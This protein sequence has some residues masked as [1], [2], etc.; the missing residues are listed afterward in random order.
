MGLAQLFIEEQVEVVATAVQLLA[1]KGRGISSWLQP[2]LGHNSPLLVAGVLATHCCFPPQDLCDHGMMTGRG[3]NGLVHQMDFM[4]SSL[5]QFLQLRMTTA[6]ERVVLARCMDGS[7]D[8]NGGVIPL[9]QQLAAAIK[10]SPETC[11]LLKDCVQEHKGTGKPTD[12]TE[13][14]RGVFA[15]EDWDGF[16]NSEW[17]RS[18]TPDVSVDV[19]P[20]VTLDVAPDEDRD[21]FENSECT[22]R[23]GSV[24][25]LRNYASILTPC[26]SLHLLGYQHTPW[27]VMN[28]STYHTGM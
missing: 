23:A 26:A 22:G 6:G 7:T 11:G 17:R 1:A 18:V 14:V 20:D 16:E 9:E 13:W 24:L 8:R 4:G 28:S 10:A 15:H 12:S 2:V 27:Q 5:V 3:F 25:S 21:G 19:T